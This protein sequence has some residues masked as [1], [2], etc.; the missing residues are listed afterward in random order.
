M[1]VIFDGSN[2]DQC[3][4]NRGRTNTPL[5]ALVMLNDPLVIEASEKLAIHL[6][7]QKSIDE[8]IEQAFLR[9]ICRKPEAKEF[10]ILKDYFTE[11]KKH[12]TNNLKLKDQEANIQALKRVNTTIFNLE[13]AITKI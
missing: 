7:E 4:V 3:E 11:E 2:R 8:A 5:Q 10:K 12:F 6:L 1:P 9:I 13:E